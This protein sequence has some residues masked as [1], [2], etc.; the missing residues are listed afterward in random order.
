MGIL[1]RK[2][3]PRPLQGELTPACFNLRRDGIWLIPPLPSVTKIDLFPF[4]L[5]QYPS[6]IVSP[7]LMVL[8]AAVKLAVSA[9]F[10]VVSRLRHVEA[11][12]LFA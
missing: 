10:V 9:V 8:S 2:T 6:R 1:S 4:P 5:A 12:P 3:L 7:C 11:E